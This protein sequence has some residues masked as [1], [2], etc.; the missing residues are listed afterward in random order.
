MKIKLNKSLIRSTLL[1][2][3]LTSFTSLAKNADENTTSSFTSAEQADFVNKFD[4]FMQ[5]LNS[6][7]DIK[8]GTSIAV[9]KGEQLIYQQNFGYADIKKQQKVTDDTLFYIASTTKPIFALTLLKELNKSKLNLDSSLATLFPKVEFSDAIQTTQINIGNLLNHTSGLADNGLG[10]VL[11][12][13][14]DYTADTLAQLLASSE[15]NT[16][17]PLNH[18]AYTNLGYNILSL[19]FEQNFQQTWQ[20][21]V[22]K[23]V[24][25]PLSMNHTSPFADDKNN[26]HNNIAKPYSFFNENIETPLYLQKKDATMHAAGGLMSNAQDMAKL[27]LVELNH[28]KLNGKQVI[29]AELIDISQQ[30]TTAVDDKKGDFIRSGYALGW[31]TGEYKSQLTYHHF[32]RFDGYRPHLSFMPELKLGL[33]ILNN[34]GDLND[35]LTDVIADFTYG[36]LLG[37]PETDARVKQRISAI[38]SKAFGAKEK[39]LVKENS[40]RTMPLQLSLDEVHYA[41]RY[42]N[43]LLGQIDIQR[44]NNGEFSFDWGNLHS[45]ATASG[46]EDML[47]IKA[48]PTRPQVVA[49]TIKDGKVAG[50][51]Y[52]GF[53]FSK[54]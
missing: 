52:G 19:A 25:K 17:S 46:K 4:L 28:G 12:I 10:T 18:F 32:G 43:T 54:L 38:K 26:H 8:T 3:I 30:V 50:L 31:Y 2:A 45:S 36:T 14:G 27:L 48:I 1:C 29:P 41:G 20:S 42:N 37:D 44:N 35:M 39:I 15:L 51:S 47:R 11:A 53:E 13:S 16:E 22:I 21:A 23:D 33:V 24:L 7:L 9:V 40:Y 49:F 5:E 34:E 6:E